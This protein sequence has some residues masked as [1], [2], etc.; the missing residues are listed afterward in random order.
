M[1]RCLICLVVVVRLVAALR[2]GSSEYDGGGDHDAAGQGDIVMCSSTALG[3]HHAH[4]GDAFTHFSKQHA[5]VEWF[6]YNFLNN[7]LIV[8]A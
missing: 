5:V 8:W 6:K 1:S 7:F 3:M 4:N 2:D